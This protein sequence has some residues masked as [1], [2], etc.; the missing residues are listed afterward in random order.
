MDSTTY[1][2][3]E[4]DPTNEYDP[5]ESLKDHSHNEDVEYLILAEKQ[6]GRYK[7][8]EVEYD[9]NKFL[10]VEDS[11]QKISWIEQQHETWYVVTT[12]ESHFRSIAM[13]GTYFVDQFR[14]CAE[15]SANK[16]LNTDAGNADAG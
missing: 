12:H 10:E 15:K 7:F 9:I 6:L 13:F 2:V 14:L 1:P 11:Q 16:S 4:Y 8:L 3:F 5:T